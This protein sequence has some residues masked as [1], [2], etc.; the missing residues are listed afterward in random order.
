MSSGTAGAEWH[1][2]VDPWISAM[3]RRDGASSLLPGCARWV[4]TFSVVGE[5][6]RARDSQRDSDRPTRGA[7]TSRRLAP[8]P[9]RGRGAGAQGP[10]ALDVVAA[11]VEMQRYRR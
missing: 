11:A 1:A 8:Q 7:T 2:S 10:D 9:R 5:L 3:R 6:S 4:R